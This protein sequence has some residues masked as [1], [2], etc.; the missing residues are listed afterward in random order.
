MSGQAASQR[1]EADDSKDVA[2]MVEESVMESIEGSPG[3]RLSP[4]VA[5]K[6]L[7]R[8]ISS[9]LGTFEGEVNM[10]RCLLWNIKPARRPERSLLVVLGTG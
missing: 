1:E 10:T 8:G 3:E 2:E 6:G 4:A 9:N 5:R 7:W